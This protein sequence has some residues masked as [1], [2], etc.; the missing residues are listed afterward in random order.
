MSTIKSLCVAV[1]FFVLSTA[2]FAEFNIPTTGS[3]MAIG[4]LGPT[5]DYTATI[6]DPNV[7]LTSGTTPPS[8]GGAAAITAYGTEPVYTETLLVQADVSSNGGNSDCGLILKFNNTGLTGYMLSIDFS[9]AAVDIM[10]LTGGGAS[11]QVPGTHASISGFSVDETYSMRFTYNGGFMTGQIYDHLGSLKAS[12]S[13]TDS[14]YGANNLTG[15]LAS[16]NV[17]TGGQDN[18]KGFFANY[19]VSAVPEPAT[20]ALLFAGVAGVF[21]KRRRG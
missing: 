18:T 12:V 20:V 7:T 19:D 11:E 8:L 21:V 4:G 16:S 1:V 13:G 3:S 9:T 15:V 17:Q 5:S 10:K 14:D 2:V 6:A